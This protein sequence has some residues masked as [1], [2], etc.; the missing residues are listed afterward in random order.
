MGVAEQF[1]HDFWSVDLG[2]HK[3]SDQSDQVESNR[4]SRRDS[5]FGEPLADSLLANRQ[6]RAR[7]PVAAR[8]FQGRKLRASDLECEADFAVRARASLS[9][10]RS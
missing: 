4:V 2:P 9:M 8:Q 5:R 7:R 3:I 10:E 6:R 1:G